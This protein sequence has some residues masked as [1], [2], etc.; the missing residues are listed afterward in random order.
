MMSAA[1]RVEFFGGPLDGDI[2]DLID[3]GEEEFGGGELVQIRVPAGVGTNR[4]IEAVVARN[5]GF[6]HIYKRDIASP[7]GVVRMD[8]AG[9]EKDV[10]AQAGGLEDG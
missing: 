3:L 10:Q 9:W 4:Y 6:I 8:Y 5:T 7:D 2:A 1:M